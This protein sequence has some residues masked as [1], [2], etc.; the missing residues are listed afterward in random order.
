MNR[1]SFFRRVGAAIA[2]YALS[3]QLAGIVSAPPKL[4]VPE[5]VKSDGLGISMRFVKEFDVTAGAWNNR[6]DVFYAMAAL[7]G[8]VRV[9][10]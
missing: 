7:E 10:G 1:R 8:P 9:E 5:F 2:G 6:I 3:G 4:V